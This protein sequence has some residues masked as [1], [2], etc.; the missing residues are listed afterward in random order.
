[1]NL[2]FFGVIIALHGV[3]E[4]VQIGQIVA[5]FV[6]AVVAGHP[7]RA[8]APRKLGQIK[9][10]QGFGCH[11]EGLAVVQDCKFFNKKFR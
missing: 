4:L 6:E 10:R 11:D 3:V 2:H 7:R 9:P 1:M 8:H 5:D